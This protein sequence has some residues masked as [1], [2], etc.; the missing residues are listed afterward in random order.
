MRLVSWFVVRRAFAPRRLYDAKEIMALLV[1]V[2]TSDPSR[3]DWLV[4][5]KLF[6]LAGGIP[7]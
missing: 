7:W 4:A 5:H 3:L 6:V 1:M 2:N